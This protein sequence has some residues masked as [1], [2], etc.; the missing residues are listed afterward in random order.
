MNDH[1]DRANGGPLTEASAG[2]EA[3]TTAGPSTSAAGPSTSAPKD[4]LSAVLEEMRKS[5]RRMEDRL[6]YLETEMHRSQDEA[7]Q[8]AAKKAKR[9]KGVVFRKKGHQEQHEFNEKVCECLEEAADEIGKRPLTESALDKAS[10]CIQEG[11]KLITAR[12]KLIRIADRSEFGWGVVAEYQAD[13]LASGSDDEKKLEKA[14]RAAERKILKK[15]KARPASRGPMPKFHQPHGGPYAVVPW[16]RP[17]G[18]QPGQQSSARG[19]IPVPKPPATIGPCY[20]CGEMGHL[21]RSCPKLL[22][23]SVRWY[24]CDDETRCKGDDGVKGSANEAPCMVK[25]VVNWDVCESKDKESVDGVIESG[26]VGNGDSQSCAKETGCAGTQIKSVCELSSDV[27]TW[28]ITASPGE[29]C[30]VR[31]QQQAD[32]VGKFWEHEGAGDAVSVKG[33]LARNVS[34]WREVVLAP[35]YILGIIQSGYVMPFQEEPTSFFRPNQASAL[36][37]ADF[38]GQAIDEL[39]ADGRVKEVTARPHVCSPLSVV[40][41]SVGKKRLVLNLRHVNKFLC[42]QKFKYEDLRVAMLL[43]EKGDYMFTFDLKSGYHHVDICPTQYKY[44]GFS[45]KG[46]GTEH[47]YVFTVLPFGL[48]TAC[49]IFTKLLRPL[50]KLWR[51]KGVKIVVYLDDG[52]GAATG[53]VG[54]DLATVLVRDTLDKAGF[55]V[56]AEKSHWEPSTTARW[57]GFLLD[58]GRGCIIVLPE[59]IVALKDR[60]AALAKADYVQ[61]R[62]LASITGTL[63]S[64]SLGVGPVSRLMTRSMYALIESRVSWCDQLRVT[65]EARGELEF[66]LSG[67]E[68][69]KSQPIWHSPSAV[70]VVYSDASDTGY[71][72]YTVEHGPYVAQGQWTQEQAEQSSTW[73]E[74]K[75]VGMVLES[76]GNKLANSRVRWFTDNQNVVRILEVGSRKLDLQQEVVRVFNLMLQY[77]IRIEPSW[78]PREQNQCADYLSRIIDYDDWQL[79]PMVFS[80]LDSVFGPHTI[81]RFASAYNTH[82]ARFNSR[83]WSPGSEAVDPFTVDWAG[84]NNWLCPPIGLIPRVLRHAQHCKA[85]GTLVVPCWESAPFWPMLC[86]D[87]TNFAAFVVGWWE[88]PQMERLFIPGRSGTALFDSKVPNTPVLAIRIQCS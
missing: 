39:I 17:A 71:G 34:F 46:D 64:M 20:S 24:P 82:L 69:F 75:A 86:P 15:K 5:E 37:N 7:V 80:M 26:L 29:A 79:N 74:L 72:G 25:E 68:V 83:Y 2:R 22:P 45:W 35:Q 42:K 57:L 50:V 88:L 13:E 9:E 41:N 38:V 16:A 85:Q 14:E 18:G 27:G 1:S 78:I 77:Q 84:E 73:R 53:R 21:K 76:L 61:A 47:Y 58:L 55:V 8:K 65:R 70:R 48:A 33:R 28:V 52:I 4:P 10:K 67:L 11:M 40:E 6:K 66:W 63:L 62:H 87:G 32:L 81:D 36:A 19:Q 12:Q 54:A 43:F 59:K 30:V 49:Y 3:A 56:H 31:S 23:A 51:S 44:L 60:I